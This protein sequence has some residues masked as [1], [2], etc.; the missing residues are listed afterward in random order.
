MSASIR[1]DFSMNEKV[2]LVNF[3]KITGTINGIWKQRNGIIMYDVEYM[4]KSGEIVNRYFS[5][6]ELRS[7]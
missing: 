2:R 5:K 6:D 4:T 3:P 1:V 7:A